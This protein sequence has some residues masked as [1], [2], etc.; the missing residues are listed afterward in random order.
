MTRAAFLL[1]AL[2][3]FSLL[4]TA[5]SGG[6]RYGVSDQAFY[7]PAI[8]LRASPDL[9]PRDRAVFE[10]QMRLWLGDE[11]LGA[12]VRRS[13]VSL[14]VLFAGLYVLTM[15]ALVGG[16]SSLA[17]ALGCRWDAVALALLVMTLRHRIARTGANSLEGYM[18]PRVLAFAVGLAALGALVRL[19]W[20]RAVAWTVLAAIVHTSTAIWFAAVIAVAALWRLPARRR[21]L[22]GAA[23]AV[24]IASVTATGTLPRMDAAWLGVLA[25][26]D[27]LFSLDWPAYAWLLNLGTAVLVAVLVRHRHRTGAAVPGEGGLAAGL[28]ALVVI[29]LGTLPATAV[30]AAAAVTLQANRVFWLLDAS[31]AILGA[32]WLARELP[33]LTRRRRITAVVLT[34]VAALSI[35]RGFYVLRIETRR[36]LVEFELPVSA[37][38]DAMT[39]LRTQPPDWHVLAD[40]EQAW[41]FGSSV[42]VAALRDTPLELGK[43]PA[44]AMYDVALARRVADRARALARFDE[45]TLPDVRRL[46]ATYDLDVLVD[47]TTRRFDLP[48]LF[49]NDEFVVYDLR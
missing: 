45:L 10:P 34:G 49:R 31:L 24:V 42:R 38:T 6:Y 41:K 18:H 47:R 3:G 26:R 15:A 23:V 20:G 9:F 35:A 2:L 33:R 29:F 43:D 44:M 22:T 1:A 13:G 5:N 16:A 46:A 12:L 19:R 40:P 37:W 8:A 4:A 36:P 25:D 7:V 14:P 27:Y 30:H 28:L 32:W 39:W 21:L 17:R 48:V 11:I